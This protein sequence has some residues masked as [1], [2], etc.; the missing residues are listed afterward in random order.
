MCYSTLLQ[1]LHAFLAR[2][3]AMKSLLALLDALARSACL[4]GSM[5]KI[6]HREV[7]I[8]PRSWI[9]GFNID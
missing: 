1:I 6:G 5:V 4:I 7:Q 2:V 9:N 3:I 8:L